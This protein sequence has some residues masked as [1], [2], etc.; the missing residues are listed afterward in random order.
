L[1]QYWT[2]G[3]NIITSIVRSYM[4]TAALYLKLPESIPQYHINGSYD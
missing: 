2:L 1:D 3:T 4:A